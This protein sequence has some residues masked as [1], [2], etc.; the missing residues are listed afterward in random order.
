VA[1]A[2]RNG[3]IH[4]LAR[5]A[6]KVFI[7]AWIA[8]ILMMATLRLSEWFVVFSWVALFTWVGMLMSVI[9]FCSLGLDAFALV[10]VDTKEL[11]GL[12]QKFN[13]LNAVM[14]RAAYSVQFA[15][16]GFATFVFTIVIIWLNTVVSHNTALQGDFML[17][18]AVWGGT[19]FLLGVT[20]LVFI[21][22]VNT[23][24]KRLPALV[25]S[26]NFG[27]EINHDKWCVAAHIEGCDAG[28]LIYNMAVAPT[29][30]M[31]FSYIILAASI[32]LFTRTV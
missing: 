1:Y 12:I 21:A 28:F 20:M 7:M 23:K 10:V 15:L 6:R 19:M 24:C 16:T 22:M 9:Y 13:V 31:K 25:H 14:R 2:C 29:S 11:A 18:L 17:K 26:L 32:F 4:T 5:Q 8:S 3:F 27:M 30:V